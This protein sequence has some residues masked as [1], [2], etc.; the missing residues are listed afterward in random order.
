MFLSL[1]LSSQ[2]FADNFEQRLTDI[3]NR[4]KNIEES[5]GSIDKLIT[6]IENPNINILDLFDNN[7]NSE[8]KISNSNNNSKIN[9]ETRK[10]YCLE[11]DFSKTIYFNYLLNN[12]YDKGIK[13]I[14]ATIKVKDLFDEKLLTAAIL[15]NAQV[16][17]NDSKFFKTTLDDTFGNKCTKLEQAQFEDYKYEFIVSKI[18]FEDNS[19]LEFD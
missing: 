12:N 13:Y 19:I 17:S 5:L 7:I 6:I 3:E 18:A 14:D 9:L 10:L 4:L 2:T 15:K 16:G 1:L 11:G 8:N